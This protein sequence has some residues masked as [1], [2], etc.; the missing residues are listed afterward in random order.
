MALE[1]S[2]FDPKDLNLVAAFSDEYLK[3]R[4]RIPPTV[5]LADGFQLAELHQCV[6]HL[7]SKFRDMA[8]HRLMKEQC[9]LANDRPDWPDAPSSAEKPTDAESARFH[10]ALYRFEAYCKL[11]KDPEVVRFNLD[12]VNFQ[13]EHFFDYLSPWEIEQLVATRDFLAAVVIGPPLRALVELRKIEALQTH[14]CGPRNGAQVVYWTA[15]ILP[16]NLERGDCHINQN[17][18]RLLCFG[19][20][21]LY[22]VSTS[23]PTQFYQ[24][25]LNL[26]QQPRYASYNRVGEIYSW[27]TDAVDRCVEMS[28]L[29]LPIRKALSSYTPDEY[30]EYVRQ[31]LIRARKKPGIGHINLFQGQ[32]AT[33]LG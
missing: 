11:F 9:S 27:F 12:I 25:L 33:I 26:P 14:H 30:K 21:F 23:P 16:P 6:G 15:P 5:S 32:P 24:L 19:I 8:L 1:S 2:K 13:R 4:P 31:S 10:R 7:G 29:E 3:R 18:A 17:Q 20:K 22:R 28:N